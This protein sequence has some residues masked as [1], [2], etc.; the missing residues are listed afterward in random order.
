[1][2][3]NGGVLLL[4]LLVGAL[5]LAP[6]PYGRAQAPPQGSTPADDSYVVKKGDTLWDIARQLYNDPL[7]WQQIWT[8]NAFIANP[9]RIFPGDTLVLP[10]KGF[11]PA[12]PVAEAPK[13]EAVKDLAAEAAAVKDMAK[14]G[15]PEEPK[16]AEPAKPTILTDYTP[17]P[18]IPVASLR[19]VLCSPVLVSERTAETLGIGTLV[20]DYARKSLLVQEDHVFL[21]LDPSQQLKAGD[22]LT[23][24]RAGLRVIH[25]QTGQRVG[26]VLNTG[27]VVEVTGV[28]E[29]VVAARVILGCDPITPGD[30][31]VPFSMPPFPPADKVAQPTTKELEGTV[32]NAAYMLEI[33]AQ[34]QLVFMDVGK[35]Q[36]VNPGDVFA[37]YRPSRP[38]VNP[39]T[40]Q[41]VGIPPERRGEATVLRVT[42]TTATAVISDS[43]SFTQ[44]G[45]RVALSRQMQP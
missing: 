18:P 39:L 30:R 45:D 21:K 15:V 37:I 28:R 41:V 35:G 17:L 33:P 36:G 44:P 43:A 40:G 9:N 5:G 1:M 6:A 3:R 20:G 7:F 19:A 12:T 31:V 24:H 10:G 4:L 26:R 27:G 29:G 2:K 14:E 8:R 42:E 34:Q 25:S 13:P 16:V 11:A 22:R 38:A 32:I 23:V